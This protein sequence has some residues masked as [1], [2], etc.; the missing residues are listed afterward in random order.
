ME[1]KEQIR[2]GLKKQLAEFKEKLVDNAKDKKL[3]LELMEEFTQL[4]LLLVSFEFTQKIIEDPEF[5]KQI[6]T[7]ID[8]EK[9]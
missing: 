4:N 8:K 5:M 7:E 3:M 1:E 9:E 2:E 6:Q